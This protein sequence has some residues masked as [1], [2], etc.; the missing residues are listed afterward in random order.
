ML[1]SAAN[2]AFCNC[3][4]ETDLLGGVASFGLLRKVGI[5]MMSSTR[6]RMLAADFMVTL[7]LKS[8]LLCKSPESSV[9]ARLAELGVI[10]VSLS[11]STMQLKANNRKC[12]F[13]K[14]LHRL[15]A[16]GLLHFSGGSSV[17]EDVSDFRELSSAFSFSGFGSGLSGSETLLPQRSQISSEVPTS[18]PARVARAWR[19]R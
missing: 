11:G 10:V 19:G 18:V 16:R 2:L 15:L 14:A 8:K 5:S 7:W 1:G 13:G 3:R 17:P 9:D 12:E 6:T 4:S